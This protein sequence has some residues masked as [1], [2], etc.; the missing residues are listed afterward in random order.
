MLE[1]GVFASDTGTVV[2]P[3]NAC[4]SRAPAPQ[5]IAARRQRREKTSPLSEVHGIPHPDAK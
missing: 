2:R 3:V 1:V 5:G 4:S